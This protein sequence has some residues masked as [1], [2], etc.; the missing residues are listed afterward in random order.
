M[1]LHSPHRRAV[2]SAGAGLL[3]HPE[4]RVLVALSAAWALTAGWFLF[5]P[6]PTEVIGRGVVI[7]PGGATVIDARPRA[8]FSTCRC[9]WEKR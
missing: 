8:R 6:V 7:V 5:W 3:H 2:K 9:G 1:N 4:Q